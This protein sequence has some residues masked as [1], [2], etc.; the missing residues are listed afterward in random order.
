MLCP[1]EPEA[2]TMTTAMRPPVLDAVEPLLARIRERA[3]EIE[4]A[5]RLPA[6]LLDELAG[7]GLFRML[8]PE[9]HGG[10]G[11]DFPT[12]VEVLRSIARADGATGWSL[13]IGTETPQLLALL[14][15]SAFDELYAGGPDL[16]VGGAF[17]P[18][19]MAQPVE[20]GYRVS[21]RWGFASG[22]EHS[23]WLFGN[24]VVPPADG[25]G[26]PSLLCALLPRD[27]WEIVDTW[28]TA[29]LRGTGSHDI[30][31]TDHFVPAAHTFDLFGGTPCFAAQGFT[32]PLLQFSMHIGAVALGIAEGAHEEVVELARTGKARLYGRS[33]M[34][35]SELFQ[36]RLGRAEADLRAAAALLDSQVREYWRLAGEGSVTPPLLDRVLQAVAWV[37]DTSATVVDACYRAGGGSA[38]YAASPLQ[39]RLR[40][41]HTLTQH[42]S[43][44]E[45]VFANSGAALMGVPAGLGL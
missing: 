33:K 23:D 32:A 29:G 28:H 45:G 9:S 37:V 25:D 10:L 7:A 22:C 39:R 1:P 2:D 34:V 13:M 6:D 42:A 5:R 4:A 12:S 38:I 16:V 11:T 36:H 15:R 35:E 18:K 17:A 8:V 19:G 24:C 41:I 3:D 27:E 44:Q 40:D 43:V 30:A 20:G 14:D 31:V 26:P 21:G